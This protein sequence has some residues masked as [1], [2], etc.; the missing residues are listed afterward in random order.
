[1]SP[2]SRLPLIRRHPE[3]THA[4][5]NPFVPVRR[6]VVRASILPYR[7]I[8]DQLPCFA[9]HQAAA[10]SY[11]YA[12]KVP[13]SPQLWT[14]YGCSFDLISRRLAICYHVRIYY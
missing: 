5:T 12:L 8:Q 4:E 9:V 13:A 2:R 14:A 10:Y 1:M 11:W 3:V 6:H 7:W